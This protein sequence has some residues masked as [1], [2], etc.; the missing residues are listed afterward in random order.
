LRQRQTVIEGVFGEAKTFHL[1][2]RALFRG[3]TKMKI[4]LLMTAA[5][6]NLK[7]LLKQGTSRPNIARPALGTM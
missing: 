7:R 3:K 6:L 1:L 2:Q 4:Q 5:V